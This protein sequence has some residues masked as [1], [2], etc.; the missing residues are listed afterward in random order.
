MND[1]Q[2]ISKK[3]PEPRCS[4][5]RISKANFH[6]TG[7]KLKKPV[8]QKLRLVLLALMA[9]LGATSVS[10][11]TAACTYSISPSSRMHGYG[12]ATNSVIVTASSNVCA[13]T[14]VNTNTWITTMSATSG[15]GDSTVNYTVAANPS[16]LARTGVVVIA[17][18][19]F[20]VQQQGVACTY[21]VSPTSRTHG[22]GAAS[23][24]VSVT[25]SSGCPWTVVN[26]NT[27]IT[28]TSPT[29]GAG[30]GTVSYEVAANPSMN[31]RTGAVLIGGESFTVTQRG[32]PCTYSIS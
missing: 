20:T 15:T 9:V 24:S 19:I 29:S 12:A 14:V 2:Q 3:R 7:I 8:N 27:W 16:P 4:E 25:T 31:D 23:N 1:I 18:Q 30:D 10:Q 28:I 17:Q 32:I 6:D 11:A 21:S 5:E 26:T 22:Y 13:W